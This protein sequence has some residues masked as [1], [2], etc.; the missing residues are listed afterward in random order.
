M[1]AV[2]APL[3]LSGLFHLAIFQFDGSSWEGPLAWR[4]PILFGI[5][6]ALTAFSIAWVIVHLPRW[7]GDG[8][9]TLAMAYSLLI[10]VGLITMQTWRGVPSHFN[11]STP[12][13]ATVAVLMTVLIV[14]FT[15]GSA[16]FTLRVFGPV[17]AP[18]VQV[19][20]MHWGM[21]WFLVSCGIGGYIQTHGTGAYGP[22]GVLKFPHGMSI[23]AIQILPLLA[24]LLPAGATRAVHWAGAGYGILTLFAL[25]QAYGGRARFDLTP[26]SGAVFALGMTCMVVPFAYAIF[27]GRFSLAKMLRGT[28]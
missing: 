11:E 3:L 28:V 13:D 24:W 20:A 19:A 22:A 12:F 25:M 2:G 10:E 5:S 15:L 17:D 9:L 21:V 18:E 27:L 16:Y 7:W 4:K 14:F 1:L 8:V 23:H 26:V 6:G